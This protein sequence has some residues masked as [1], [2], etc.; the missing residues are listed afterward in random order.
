MPFPLIAVVITMVLGTGL[1]AGLVLAYWPR[2][3]KAARDH[4]LPWIERHAPQLAPDVRQAFVVLDNLAV[5][6]RQALKGA[7]RRVRAVLLDEVARFVRGANERWSLQVT[8]YLR[9]LERREKPFVRVVTEEAV[10]YEDLPANVREADLRSQIS[11]DVNLTQLMDEA[12]T[13]KG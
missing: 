7:W 4:L 5:S 8:S 2:L 11:D 10:D 12:M 13:E 9:N 3:I 6:A 1:L